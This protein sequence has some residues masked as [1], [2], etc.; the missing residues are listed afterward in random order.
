M[1]KIFITMFKTP[2]L[3]NIKYI[4][5]NEPCTSMLQVDIKTS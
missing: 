1:P 2:Q 3:P 5:S 4:R